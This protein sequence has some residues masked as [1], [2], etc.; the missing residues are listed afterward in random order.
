M[1]HRFQHPTTEQRDAERASLDI[2]SCSVIQPPAT[3]AKHFASTWAAGLALLCLGIGL[4]GA[5]EPLVPAS[6]RLDM[7]NANDEAVVETFQLPAAAPADESPPEPAPTEVEDDIEI[8][9]LPEVTPPLTPPEM[10]EITPLEAIREAP[11]IPKLAVMEKK[12]EPPK[13]ATKATPRPA[14]PSPRNTGG[15]STGGDG[16]APVLFTGRG[17][18]GGR[19]PSPSYPASARSAKQQGTV[20]ILVTVEASGIPSS[21][22]IAG[23]SGYAALDRTAR[24]TIQ[25]RWRWPAGSVRRYIVP[26]R[27]HLE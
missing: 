13:P 26:V 4:H 11:P 22:E 19:F 6:P 14:P 17:S 24:D 7:V 10:V 2:L 3:P 21:V 23:S 9:P 27:F 25:R 8:P 12:P 16:N 15:T 1:R 18:G 5:T 20:R